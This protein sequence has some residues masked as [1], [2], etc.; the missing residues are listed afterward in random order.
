MI[1]YRRIVFSLFSSASIAAALYFS[2]FVQTPNYAMTGIWL[3]FSLFTFAF[4]WP[5]IAKNISFLGNSIELRELQTK[6]DKLSDQLSNYW[7]EI[8]SENEKNDFSVPIE[9]DASFEKLEIDLEKTID[10]A[11]GHASEIGHRL[12]GIWDEIIAFLKSNQMDTTKIEAITYY[13]NPLYN[14]EWETINLAIPNSFTRLRA[15]FTHLC[16]KHY[17]EL[18]NKGVALSAAESM[19]FEYLKEELKHYTQHVLAD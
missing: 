15:L 4:G 6:V 3:T 9:I 5:E 18:T 17:E 12:G 1:C 10:F 2:F 14:P 13:N 16:L 7:K 19:R 8:K 11:A